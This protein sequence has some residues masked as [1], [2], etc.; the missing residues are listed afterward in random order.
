MLYYLFIFIYLIEVIYA[1]FVKNENQIISYL[2]N[3]NND[4]VYLNINSKINITEKITISNSIK[5]LSIV[6]NSPT[7]TKLYLQNLLYFDS[8]VEKVEIKNI[9]IN[10]ILFFKNNKRIILNNVN[11]YGYIDSDF[12]NHSNEYVNITKLTYE[13]SGVSV[14]NCINLSGNVKIDK[15]YFYGD[16]SCQNRLLHYNGLENYNFEC[17]R[18]KFNGKNKCPFL[19][20]EYASNAN[21]DSSNFE[22]GYSS[23]N[24]DGGYIKKKKNCV[25]YFKHII[26]III[27]VL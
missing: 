8:S 9:N 7:S 4:N 11:L 17:K 16:S 15:S 13:P 5:K 18:S 19:S 25:I 24:V 1:V 21:I 14:H 23:K 27:V 26:S 2:S 12:N 10:G 22:K 6:G 20:I 3:N